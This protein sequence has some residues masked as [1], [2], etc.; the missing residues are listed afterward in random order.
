MNARKPD[1]L[2]MS[3]A[4]NLIRARKLFLKVDDVKDISKELYNILDTI[5][6]CAM[7]HGAI[8]IH[9]VIIEKEKVSVPYS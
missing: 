9:H 2:I 3:D 7:P 6:A 5:H 4:L 1:R 8:N